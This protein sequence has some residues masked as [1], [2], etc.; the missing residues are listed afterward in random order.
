MSH[1]ILKWKRSFCILIKSCL[2]THR[3]KSIFDDHAE[4]S[5]PLKINHQKITILALNLISSTLQ[6]IPLF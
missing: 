5:F 6:M 1:S 3:L 4:K 2:N